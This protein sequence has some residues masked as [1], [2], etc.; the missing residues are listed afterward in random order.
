MAAEH[1]NVQGCI[2]ELSVG[3]NSLPST[4][5]KVELRSASLVTPPPFWRIHRCAD[6]LCCFK[7][8]WQQG[9]VKKI[10]FI[11]K[12]G[13]KCLMARPTLISFTIEK[14]LIL[15]LRLGIRSF[16][17]LKR[18]GVGRAMEHLTPCY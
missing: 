7:K 14:Y 6:G 5:L 9:E 17:G 16:S 2:E 13:V 15:S 10:F 18:I 1:L 3:Q 11:N 4:L 8:R 12:K